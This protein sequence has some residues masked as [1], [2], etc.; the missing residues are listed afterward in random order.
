M[1]LRLNGS[2]SGFTEIDAPAVAGNN[3]I[4]LPTGNGSAHQVLKNNTTAGELVFGLSLPSGNGTNGQALTT[5]GA[6]GSSWSTLALLGV[7]QTWQNVTA[8]RAFGTTYT[9]STGKPIEV[10]IAFANPSPGQS[11]VLTV[12][13]V[14]I[15]FGQI[16]SAYI[17]LASGSAIVPLGATYVFN[18]TTTL[19]QWM[20]LR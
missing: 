18:T 17:N 2:T 10:V 4:K 14:A 12:G 1:T 9:N 6:G 5:D 20:E 15:Q 13:G 7:G 8:S 16:N 3:N 19:I 11:G